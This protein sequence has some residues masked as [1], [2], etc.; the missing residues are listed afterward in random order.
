[1]F[2]SELKGRLPLLA[3]ARWQMLAAFFMTGVI[4]LMLG[5]WRSIGPWQV[6]LLAAS[7]FCGICI[8]STTY[9]AAI[10]A[11]GPRITALLFSLTSPFA[12]ALGYLVLGETIA[13]HQALG[14]VL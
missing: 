7:S 5:G 13:A 1:M 10:Y 14:V 6:G 4:S 2:I 3:L 9:F 11:V 12:L 8:A